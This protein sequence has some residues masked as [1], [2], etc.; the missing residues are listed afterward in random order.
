MLEH[1][2][3]PQLLR[4]QTWC[5]LHKKHSDSEFC[6]ANDSCQQVKPHF[7]WQ[8]TYATL[9]Y[10]R[11]GEIRVAQSLYQIKDILHKM[12]RSKSGPVPVPNKRHFTQEGD[13]IMLH[14]DTPTTPFLSPSSSMISS[15]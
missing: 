8:F 5:H 4:V 11:W 9:S 2:V 1:T 14:Q 10:T 12:G 15:P 7:T 3:Y 13:E 6:F